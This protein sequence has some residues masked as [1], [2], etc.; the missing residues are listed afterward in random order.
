MYYVISSVY[1]IEYLFAIEQ[2]FRKY[3]KERNEHVCVLRSR[4]D[5]VENRSQERPKASHT[6]SPLP[7][8][9]YLMPLIEKK[10]LYALSEDCN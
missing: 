4:E 9:S 1:V 7:A 5:N 8:P 3:C 10:M 6:S 2:G